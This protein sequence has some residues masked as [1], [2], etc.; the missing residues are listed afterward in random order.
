MLDL[1][2]QK[3]L[4]EVRNIYVDNQGALALAKNAEYHA[5]TKHIDIQY[6]FVRQHTETEKV[7]LTYCAT[8]EMTADIFTKAL[9]QPAFTC[10][11][12]GLG[13]IDRS[14]LLFEQTEAEEDAYQQPEALDES[15]GEGRYC[16]SPMLSGNDSY[17]HS[18]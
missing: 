14:V 3:H 10:H 1:E 6:H 8:S 4:Q 17:L 11:N 18:Y 9:P 13:L 15:T 2:A 5:R 12:L 16:K 7:I